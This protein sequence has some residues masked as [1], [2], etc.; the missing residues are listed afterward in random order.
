MDE[1]IRYEDIAVC[2]LSRGRWKTMNTH[3]LP[4]NALVV[5]PVD[6]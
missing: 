4:P 1:L 5:V 3:R 2:I 6:L